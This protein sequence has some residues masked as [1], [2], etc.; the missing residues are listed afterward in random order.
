MLAGI[1]LVAVVIAA[2]VLYGQS[3]L[4]GLANFLQGLA[5]WW[6]SLF[7]GGPRGA[8][9]AATVSAP[10]A[11]RPRPFREFTDPFASGLARRSTPL[12]LVAYTFQALEAWAYEAG[13]PRSADQTPIEFASR[14][15]AE[16][17]DLRDPAKR[18]GELVNCGAYSP[19]G[20]PENAMGELQQFWRSL[21]RPA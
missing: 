10:P 19:Q 4:A 16:H 14:L 1:A 12:E 15:A 3:W 13:C 11:P 21:P 20:L 18:L 6:A 5:A 7:Q 17:P 8:T 2:A 9:A